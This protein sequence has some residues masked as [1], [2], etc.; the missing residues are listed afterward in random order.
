[1]VVLDMPRRAV[2]DALV[3]VR[4]SVDDAALT[5]AIAVSIDFVW[6][7]AGVGGSGWGR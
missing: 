3:T 4:S 6:G 5:A 7:R 2:E 1:M